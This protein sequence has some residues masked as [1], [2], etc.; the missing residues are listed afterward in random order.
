MSVR[1]LVKSCV[2]IGFA[3]LLGH[4]P[5]TKP[6]GCILECAYLALVLCSCSARTTC[7]SAAS[8]EFRPLQAMLT[9]GL[10]MAPSARLSA[11]RLAKRCC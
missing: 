10:Q 8:L 5:A 11:S 2:D 9:E 3:H 4:M 1:A 6:W 7:L